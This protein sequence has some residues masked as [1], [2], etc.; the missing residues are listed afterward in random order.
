LHQGRLGNTAIGASC[1]RTE[2]AERLVGPTWRNFIN[3]A[4]A[5]K[6][7]ASRRAVEV[8][9]AGLHGTGSWIGAGSAA[10]LVAKA[11]QH[12]EQAC[13]G[14]FEESALTEHAAIPCCAVEV[15]VTAL[16]EACRAESV[17]TGLSRTKAVERGQFATNCHFVDRAS[18]DAVAAAGG[19]A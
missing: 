18:I 17:G 13:G 16:D 12:L 19:G 2:L 10:R 3:H 8:A 5:M 9:V 4:S 1:L 6:S 15:T 7:S 11:M 14:E